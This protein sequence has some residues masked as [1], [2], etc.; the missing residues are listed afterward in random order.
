MSV[1]AV[2]RDL[3]SALAPV[4]EARGFVWS[5]RRS[6]FR[7]R[8]DGVQ[9]L[10]QLVFVDYAPVVEVGIELAVRHD[11]VESVFHRTSGIDKRY[12][13]GTSTIG[14]DFAEVTGIPSARIEIAPPGDVGEA[15]RRL[16]ST[17]EPAE[18]YFAR[19]SD[20]AEVDRELNSHPECR[21]PN[22]PMPWLR[23]STGLIVARLVGRPDYGLLLA[24][25]REQMATVNDS[26]YL[27]RFTRL[28]R[29]LV[30]NPPKALPGGSGISDVKE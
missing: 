19:F 21:T 15:V 23:C 10:L 27:A 2:T 17:V 3:V 16:I 4:L 24:A 29:D 22:R 18:R 7:R 25:Y 28:A 11:A 8:T 12:Q 6:A 9:H 5:P 13:A 14:G 30:D 1:S 20:L 26:F